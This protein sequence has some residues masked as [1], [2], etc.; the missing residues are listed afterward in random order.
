MA[1]DTQTARGKI[2]ALG[3]GTMGGAI[4]VAIGLAIGQVAAYLLS[5]AGARVLGPDA[6]GVFGSMLALMMVGAVLSL[7]LQAAGAKRVVLIDAKHRPFVGSGVIRWSAGASIAI[8]VG[9]IVVSPLLDW[10]LHLEGILP[11]VLV[12]LNL[13]PTTFWGG[14]LGV[15]QG[16]EA[17]MRLA[18]I[19]A[20]VGLGRAIGGIGMIMA[21]HSVVGGLVGMAIGT[22][23]GTALCWLFTTALIDRPA[24]KLVGFRVDITH[25]THALLALFVLT[26]LDVLLA[27]HFLAPAQ[28][29]MYAAGAVVTKVAFWLPQFVATIAYPRMTDHRRANALSKGVL[30]V[31]VIGALAIAVVAL[32]PNLVV[33]FVGGSAYNDLVSEVWIF[34]AI[35]AAYALAQFCLYGQIAAGKRAAIAVLWLGV[36]CLIALVIMFHSSVL[37]IAL[38]VLGVAL[39]LSLIGLAELVTEVRREARL[40]PVTA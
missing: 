30:A 18:A 3:R 40:E 31:V 8:A 26:N 39:A 17:H 29:G 36:A 13:A 19:Y 24:Q 35:G 10:L 9:T 21:T 7:G 6:Y 27:R 4:M 28:A 34:A 22:W 33:N 32:L 23:V 5:L 1:T 37:Q 2:A 38:C 20:V 25:A 15:A 11:I 16:R 14:L 12:A